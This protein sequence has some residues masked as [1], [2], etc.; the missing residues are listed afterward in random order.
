MRL[1]LLLAALL[2][3]RKKSPLPAVLM[4]SPLRLPLLPAA[5]PISRKKN[6]PLAVPLVALATRNKNFFPPKI[7]PGG[8]Y[9][10]GNSLI[11]RFFRFT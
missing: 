6:L 3:S 5:L 11:T 2:T 7:V 1:P 10:A 4:I 9:P 8:K